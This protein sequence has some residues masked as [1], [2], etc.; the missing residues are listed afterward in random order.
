MEQPSPHFP[1]QTHQE[2]KATTKAYDPYTDPLTVWRRGRPYKYTNISEVQGMIDTYLLEC[3]ATGKIPSISGLALCLDTHRKVLCEW[4]RL[5]CTEDDTEDEK[6]FKA[7]LRNTVSRAKE[8]IAEWWT[9]GLMDRDKARGT[10]FYLKTLG[11]QD[12][13]DAASVQNITVN[14]QN[15]V[16]VGNPA[17]LSDLFGGLLPGPVQ[18]ALD[19]PA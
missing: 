16:L 4:E 10:E 9:P 18:K 8:R 19:K 1:A 6:L 12:K 7:N 11:Y 17:L 3:D 15:N 13:P 2:G 5:T 14:Q